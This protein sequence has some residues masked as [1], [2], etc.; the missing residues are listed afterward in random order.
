MKGT[1]T[2]YLEDGVKVDK[3]TNPERHSEVVLELARHYGI[4]ANLL[5]RE[6]PVSICSM[7]AIPSLTVYELSLIWTPVEESGSS[8]VDSIHT[9]ATHD[10]AVF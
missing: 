7:W 6:C 10:I 2:G 4:P 9:N 8:K 1:Q 5:D 3:N